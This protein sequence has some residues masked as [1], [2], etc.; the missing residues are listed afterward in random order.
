MF[1]GCCF[2]TSYILFSFCVIVAPISGIFLS[3]LEFSILDWLIFS[4]GFNRLVR[5]MLELHIWHLDLTYTAVIMIIFKSF[6][7]MGRSDTSFLVLPFYKLDTSHRQM[8][9]LYYVYFVV[10]EPFD[11]WLPLNESIQHQ[12]EAWRFSLHCA[13]EQTKYIIYLISYLLNKWHKLAFS[14]IYLVLCTK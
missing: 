3:Y 11:V 2:Q 13:V 4:F 7:L 5:Y 10:L 8:V 12:E 9:Y 6:C 1:C 14:F